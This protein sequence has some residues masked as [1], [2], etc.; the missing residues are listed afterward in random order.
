MLELAGLAPVPLVG[1]ILADFGAQVVRVSKP[2]ADFP[3]PLARGKRS[4]VLDTSKAEGRALLRRLIWEPC[5]TTAAPVDV[6]LDPY[7]P[8]VLERLLHPDA[9]QI[10]SAVAASTHSIEELLPR[11]LIL[12]RVSGYGHDIGHAYAR[13]AGHDINYL[14][15]SGVLSMLRSGHPDSSGLQTLAAGASGVRDTVESCDPRVHSVAPAAAGRP[16]PPS[17]LLADFAGGSLLAVQGILMALL[18]RSMTPPGSEPRGQVVDASMTAG[19]SY[20]ATLHWQ[21]LR[22]TQAAAGAQGRATTA[23]AG[24][25]SASAPAQAPSSSRD[26]MFA[27]SVVP[28]LQ[29]GYAPYY[30]SYACKAE[31]EAEAGGETDSGSCT[32]SCTVHSGSAFVAVGSIEGPFFSQL[33]SGLRTVVAWPDD[34]GLRSAGCADD[35]AKAEAKALVRMQNDRSRWPALRAYLQHA[36]SL[37]PRSFWCQSGGVFAPEGPFGDACVSPV[38]LPAEAMHLQRHGRLPRLDG[39]AT[40]TGSEG[41]VDVGA[42]GLG[43]PLPAPRLSRTPDRFRAAAAPTAALGAATP[44]AGAFALAADYWHAD[45]GGTAAAR[46]GAAADAA[47]GIVAAGAHTDA[48]LREMLALSDAELSRLRADGV[49]A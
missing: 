22:M 38:L 11:R 29:P 9:G 19:A 27:D 42:A 15:A 34:L 32:T 39:A 28:F 7:R 4:I 16:V 35:D 24:T 45:D 5:T 13:A 8:G 20:L 3:D 47:R 10:Q 31:A 2:T 41:S 1:Q 33:M 43:V 46:A 48:V 44:D 40:A 17:N 36:F 18:Q 14:A 30:D 25:S 21:L 6:L 49:I 26:L 37:R 12:A 23:Q